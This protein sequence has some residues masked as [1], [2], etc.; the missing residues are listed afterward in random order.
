MSVYNASSKTLTT[1][2]SGT[3]Y[4]SIV[5]VNHDGSKL[6]LGNTSSM[7]LYN[8]KLTLLGAVPGT[9]TGFGPNFRLDGGLL[10]SA[11]GTQV[12]EVGQYG[13]PAILTIDA[14][15]PANLTVVQIAPTSN[16]Q[17]GGAMSSTPTPFAI[18]ATGMILGVQNYGISFDDSTFYQ[19]Y[20]VSQPNVD[21]G[22]IYT[23]AY[24]G[25]LAGGTNSS[26]YAFPSLTPDVWFGQTRG[27][28]S[29]SQS[30]GSIAKSQLTFTS[31]PSTT[32]GP[33][34]VKF[35]YP[36][37][38]TTFA[39]QLFSY[40]TFPEY[41][42]LS[43]SSP[44]GGAPAQVIGYGLPQD[45][46]GGTV[47]VGSNV[48]TITSAAGLN[49]PFSAE[50]IPSTVLNYTFPQGTPGWADLQI[51]TPIGTGTLPKSI[52]YAKS[53]TDYS[54]T[55]TFTAVLF[56][57]KRNQVYLSA[58]DHIDVFSTTSNAFVTPLQPAAITTKKEFAGLALT[59]DGTQLIVADLLDNSVAVINPDTLST[60]AIPIPTGN[61]LPGCTIGPLYV[62]ATSAKQAFVSTGSLPGTGCAPSYL[63]YITNLQTPYA[64]AAAGCT[65]GTGLDAS[66]DGNF[67]ITGNGPC[68]YSVQSSSYNQASF[69]G[70]NGSYGVS[71]SGDGNV[72]IANE[73]LG[74]INLNMLGA[75]ARPIPFYGTT[76][77]PPPNY[78]LQPRLNAVG[79][80]YYFATPN[81]FEIIDV[82]HAT[83]CM[84]FALTET[85]QGTASPI[86][87]DSGGRFV[88]LITNQGLTMVDLGAAP[89]SIGH[90]NPQNAAPNTQVVVR[91]SGF[92]SS[93]TATVGGVTASVSF[94]DQNTL[95]STVPAA[96]S[97]PED[98][99]LTRGDGEIYTL[100]NGLVLP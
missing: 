66:G 97:G 53:V 57:A 22:L 84:R 99:V 83:L 69:P 40:S 7:S 68:I 73:I 41:A 5:A 80:L 27:T 59:P 89:L 82:A 2:N 52:F 31:P 29:V 64:V 92:D 36:D 37:G 13:V 98:I 43:G 60:F 17:G 72:I 93:I 77:S 56:D 28:A 20:A 63:T 96:L 47:V 54:S 25:P 87:I 14:S 38:E 85:V 16:S 9:L 70:Y 39:E 65:R 24:A 75:I 100:E 91:G 10:F 15:N 71:I 61:G 1:L 49:V 3:T 79:S 46:S 35:I 88:Y 58:G 67:V 55:D 6:V 12:Y 19:T 26:L 90:L 44:I 76:T 4:N 86:A 51:S 18:D 21:G 32:P 94:T 45:P 78:L 48:A 34:N 50:P 23:S 81:N 62:A 42:V 74:D 8:S 30:A 11:D 95:T 33:V